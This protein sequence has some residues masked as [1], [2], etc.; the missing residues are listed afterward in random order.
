M[1]IFDVLSMIFGGIVQIMKNAKV[2][3]TTWW[4]LTLGMMVLCLMVA[5]YK[6]FAGGGKDG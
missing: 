6:L 1:D 4:N 2:L 5:I 3:G